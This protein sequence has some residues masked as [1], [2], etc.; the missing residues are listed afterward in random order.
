MRAARAI[1][2]MLVAIACSSSVEAGENLARFKNGKLIVA[3][4][5]CAM[6]RDERTACVIKCNGS[7]TCIGN[8]DN[9]YQLCVER[10]CR[11]RWW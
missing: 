1:C 6:C 5:H 7:G 2:L 10:A 11:Y 4:S 8:C 3:Q 9:D